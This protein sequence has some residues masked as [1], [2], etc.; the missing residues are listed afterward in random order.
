MDTLI[1]PLDQIDVHSMGA[2]LVIQALP[3]MRLGMAAER[4]K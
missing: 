2:S 1:A 4:T 3:V